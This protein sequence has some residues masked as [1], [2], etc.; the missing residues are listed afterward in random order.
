MSSDKSLKKLNAILSTFDKCAIAFSGGVDSTFLLAAAVR[1]LGKENVTAITVI[2]PYVAD[3]EIKEADSLAADL[4]VKHLQIQTEMLDEVKSNPVNRCYICKTALF[5]TMLDKCRTFDVNIL[6]DGSNADDMGDFRPGMK[7]LKELGIH[8]PLLEAGMTKQEIRE[9]SLKWELDTWNKPPYACLL[10][11]IPHETSVTRQI[12]DRI[13]NS[14]VAMIESGFP[15]VRVRHHGD[16][17]RIEIPADQF[18]DFFSSGKSEE[19]VEK[20]KDYGYKFVTLDLS[21]YKMGS[22][23]RKDDSN[24]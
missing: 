6:C 18:N 19:I 21:G 13:E 16:I 3:W 23:N 11:R 4:G 15:Y 20:L 22:M 12:L 8:S 1:I 7:A 5:T 10:T 9:I 17:A 2:P 14:E 24:G